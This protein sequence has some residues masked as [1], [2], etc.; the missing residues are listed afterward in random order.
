M[1]IKAVLPIH[2]PTSSVREQSVRVGINV[3]T[4]RPIAR[5]F[6]FFASSLPIVAT[7]SRW[8]L[9]VFVGDYARNAITLGWLTGASRNRR[10]GDGVFLAIR[11]RRDSPACFR[12]AAA[13]RGGSLILFEHF[14]YLVAIR[15]H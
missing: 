15:W 14:A 13:I 4:F 1:R 5:F 3:R 6:Y 12:S 10:A 8:L 7:L 9:P 2:R 11:S